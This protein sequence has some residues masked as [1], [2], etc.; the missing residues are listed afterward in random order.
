MLST[1]GSRSSRFDDMRTVVIKEP[2]RVAVEEVEAPEPEPGQI[3]VRTTLSGISAGTEMNLYRGTNPD[4]VRRRWGER[5]VYP[6]VP[7]YQALG[8][9]VHRSPDVTSFEVGDRVFT[10][11]SHSE[12]TVADANRC[13]RLPD[14]LSDAQASLLSVARVALHG[15]R[16]S[17]IEYGDSVAV[18]G[19][20]LMGQ[21]A[22]QH[23][24]LAGAARTIA[25]DIDPWRLEIARELGAD[26][27]I[28]PNSG[29]PAEQIMAYTECGADV[30][31]ET[32]GVSSA[33][34]IAL[35][36]G[37]YAARVVIVGWHLQPISID[38]AE[39]L[40]YKELD[41]L[42]SRAGG[43][44]DEA[45]PFVLRWNT[46]RNTEHLIRLLVDRSMR[47]DRLIT[48]VVPAKDIAAVYEMIHTRSEQ[49]LH[50]ALDWED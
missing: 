25:V 15:V 47:V 37:R 41:L 14:D 39:D 42:P 21:L 13:F 45:P 49:S 2:Y 18:V 7:G 29:D 11:G 46:R 50:V 5:F 9:V 44:G 28:D 17:R 12:F 31:L 26:H 34:P 6:F 40:L 43:L 38:L 20:G 4:L 19:M 36:L 3:L 27:A 30:V 32:A 48:H 10:G 22:I 24:R 8:I 16:R 1:P 33:V 23:A 35:A